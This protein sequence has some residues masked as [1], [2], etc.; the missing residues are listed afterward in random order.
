MKLINLHT[1]KVSGTPSVIE[2]INQ[3]P[4]EFIKTERFSIGIHPWRIN[5]QKA[6]E[7]LGFIEIKLNDSACLVIGECGLDKRIE[8]P[9]ELQ[10]EIFKKHLDLAQ[11]FSKPIIVHCVAAYQEVIELCR[12]KKITIPVIIHGFSKNI[13][14]AT[15]LVNAGFYLSFGKWLMQNPELSLVLK[16]IPD[17][18]Y[19]LETDSSDFDIKTIYEKASIA[20]G[21]DLDQIAAQM[22]VNYNTVF[23][24]QKDF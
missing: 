16:E 10:T 5:A 22:L 13:Q 20:K 21:L 12:D 19:F 17:N 8:T 14:V 2:I 23:K 1:H 18:R 4:D 24:T 3:Y 6:E 11:K 15:A 7:Q 9:I